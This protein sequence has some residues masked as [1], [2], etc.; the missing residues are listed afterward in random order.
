MK[1]QRRP[2]RLIQTRKVAPVAIPKPDSR[3][4]KFYRDFKDM[5]E[6]LDRLREGR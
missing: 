2:Q 6:R 3:I 4:E 5:I 1:R